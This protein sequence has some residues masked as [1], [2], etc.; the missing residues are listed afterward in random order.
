MPKVTHDPT[1]SGDEPHPIKA[2]LIHNLQ[3]RGLLAD[4]GVAMIGAATVIDTAPEASHDH[5]DAKIIHL[6]AEFHALEDIHTR[7]CWVTDDVI[8][9]GRDAAQVEYDA[10]QSRQFEV[11]NALIEATPTTLEGF[12]AKARAAV[13]WY[14]DTGITDGLG[15]DIAWA[16]LLDLVGED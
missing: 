11:G 3:R 16:L 8:R 15:G 6:A 2:A 1:P 13:T 10:S 7:T 4:A 5:P 12:R 14:G 9:P